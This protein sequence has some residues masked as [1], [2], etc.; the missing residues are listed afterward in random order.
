[1]NLIYKI[2]AT[3]IP[4]WTTREGL[5]MTEKFDISKDLTD[6]QLLKLKNHSPG[7]QTFDSTSKTRVLLILGMSDRRVNPRGGLY[8]YKK[9][10]KLGLDIKLKV[11]EGEGHG[12]SKID[13]VFENIMAY[14][15]VIFG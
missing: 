14:F 12:I 6:E 13:N 11:Y 3:D 1:M 15:K 5:G 4:E 2:F 7:L 10:K 9:L 8:L